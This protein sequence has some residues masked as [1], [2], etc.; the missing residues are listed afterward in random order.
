VAI[1][2]LILT[3]L[4]A[5]LYIQNR[6][7]KNQIS[8]IQRIESGREVPSTTPTEIVVSPTPEVATDGAFFELPN[9]LPTALQE[10]A[11]AQ[12]LMVTTDI[13]IPSGKDM[14]KAARGT[15]QYWFRQGPGLATYFQVVKAP[16][17]AP[18]VVKPA[19]VNPDNNIPDLLPLYQAKTLGIDVFQ[20]NAIAWNQVVNFT[21]TSTPIN[22][23][24]KYIRSMPTS[25]STSE[26]NIW[27]VTYKFD[28]ASAVT[29]KVVQI[30]ANSQQILY[31]NTPK[32]TSGNSPS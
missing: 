19:F 6:G 23:S 15:F 14:T 1:A 25:G 31:V 16:D 28:P 32:P 22:I 30:D 29:D 4:G 24:A 9:I 17:S 5:F 27:Q 3:T 20:A 11:T 2:V 26:V 8:T 12:L 21:G 10:S 7:L 18:T 13:S